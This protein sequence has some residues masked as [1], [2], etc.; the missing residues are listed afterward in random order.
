VTSGDQRVEVQT[1]LETVVKLLYSTLRVG[2]LSTPVDGGVLQTRPQS[3]P[4]NGQPPVK[5]KERIDGLR[6]VVDLR[7]G[8]SGV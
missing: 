2:R 4:D 8:T 7:T 6:S 3:S 5:L 1:L